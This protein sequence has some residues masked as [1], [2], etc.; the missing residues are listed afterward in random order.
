MSKFYLVNFKVYIKVKVN[1]LLVCILGR[2]K[3]ESN[4]S[5]PSSQYRRD[6][7]RGTPQPEESSEDIPPREPTPVPTASIFMQAIDWL[8]EVKAVPV[9]KH[10]IN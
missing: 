8:L 5:R 7:A 6:S 3:S 4:L 2:Q 1:Y 10:D 9:S